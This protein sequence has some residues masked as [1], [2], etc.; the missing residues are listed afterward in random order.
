MAAGSRGAEPGRTGAALADAG[1]RVRYAA[2]VLLPRVTAFSRPVL[3]LAF[4]AA[5]AACGGSLPS[6]V[7]RDT[8]ATSPDPAGSL[9]SESPHA[10]ETT[11]EPSSLAEPS[12]V[13]DA[14]PEPTN[15]TGPSSAA[16]S[17]PSTAA[18]CTG[19][20]AN[21]EF[22][23]NV[24]AAVDWT[25]SCAVL[26]RG[27][28]VNTGRYRLANGGNL[29][30]S[31]K[32]PNGASLALSE[33]GFCSD[34]SGCVPPGTEAGDAA[35]GRQDGTLVQ[36]DDGGWAIVVDRGANPSW[37]L[38]AEGLGKA[39]TIGVGEALAQVGAP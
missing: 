8:P 26:P 6:S 32:G 4:A 18:A 34:G 20:D 12:A 29:V 15:S 30:I 3:V 22:F 31:Y 39:A 24:A 9:I 13:P 38:V 37:L 21:R 27:W 16:T 33:G 2:L 19:N 35:F 36:L 17:E 23:A 14:T 7:A 25:V 28:F 5:V 1:G 10:I 11:P